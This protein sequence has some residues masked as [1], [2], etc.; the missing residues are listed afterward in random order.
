MRVETVYDDD[1]AT[2]KVILLGD[3]I[4]CADLL[5]LIAMLAEADR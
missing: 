4:G 3:L 1:R 2:L 5:R